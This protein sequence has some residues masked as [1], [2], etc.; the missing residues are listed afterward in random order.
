MHFQWAYLDEEKDA[1][2]QANLRGPTGRSGRFIGHTPDGRVRYWL[3][4]GRLRLEFGGSVLWFGEFAESVPGGPEGSRTLYG[5]A[6]I[7]A[8]L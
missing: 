2:I 1:W 7:T 5:F 4:Q 8:T 3:Q 6:Q